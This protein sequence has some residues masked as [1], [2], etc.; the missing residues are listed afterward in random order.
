ML[1]DNALFWAAAMF[2]LVVLV[3]G[4]DH[5]RRGVGSV[6]ADVFWVG[7]SAIFLE[8]AL[9][10]VGV[11]RHRLA[12]LASFAGGASLAVGYVVVHFLPGRSWLSDSFT[13]AV[14]VSMLS[15]TAATLEVLAA[16]TLGIVGFLVLR[17][18]G[19]LVSA[20]E[21]HPAQ[22]PLRVALRHPVSVV[23]IVGNVVILGISFAD[24]L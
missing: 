21:A 17:E 22:R 13:S 24:L 14:N 8:V 12:P 4:A 1:G 18:R 11:Q 20:A 3:H 19:G 15:W 23:M 16:T 7:T 6:G 9:V 5:V 10:V 2:G